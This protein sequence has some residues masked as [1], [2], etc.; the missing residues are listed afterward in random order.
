[1]EIL[2]LRNLHCPMPILKTKQALQKMN[3]GEEITVV[4]T[5]PHS[6]IDFKAFLGKTSN[7]LMKF[8]VKDGEYFFIIK[9]ING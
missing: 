3:E 2:D 8:W 1:M 9:K 7:Q 4:T 5:D 6:E